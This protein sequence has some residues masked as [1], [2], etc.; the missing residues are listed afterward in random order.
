MAVLSIP[1]SLQA[2]NLG[3]IASSFDS[4]SVLYYAVV[5]SIIYILLKAFRNIFFS[6]IKHIPG[7]YT[8]AAR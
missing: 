5:G 1:S 2:L 7:P 3:K 4:L 8:A 6:P